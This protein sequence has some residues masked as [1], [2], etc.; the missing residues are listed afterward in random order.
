MTTLIK[1]QDCAHAASLAPAM[2]GLHR[3]YDTGLPKL[4]QPLRAH[5]GVCG[6]DGV[7]WSPLETLPAAVI[8]FPQ[9]HRVSA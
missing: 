7:F 4:C 3:D 9:A 1:C 2:C 6:P 8:A 5:L